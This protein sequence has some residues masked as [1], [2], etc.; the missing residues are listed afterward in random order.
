[1][2]NTNTHQYFCQTCRFDT[3]KKSKWERHLSTRKHKSNICMVIEPINEYSSPK[4]THD[5]AS[6]GEKTRTHTAFIC[7]CGKTY[8][9]KSNYSRHKKKC[10]ADGDTAPIIIDA[11][12]QDLKNDDDKID[13][14]LVMEIIKENKELRNI[15]KQQSEQISE[16]IPKIGNITN[17]NTTNKFNLNVFL[18]ERCK[19]ALNLED[20][21]RTI[22]LQ[23]TDLE[24][25][26]RLG[27]VNGMTNIIVRG[28]NDL[29]VTK[30]P[31]H[32]S[33]S[34]RDIL[35]VKDNNA[36]E[37]DNA[38][39][40]KMKRAI[41][42]ISRSN[43]KQIPNWVRENPECA[44]VRDPKNDVYMNMINETMDDNQEQQEKRNAKI[45]K[46]IAKTIMID[47]IDGTSS[48]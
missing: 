29:E 19:D 34:K 28:L 41:E 24:D 26:A 23:I 35:Y 3:P 9:Y 21:V 8:A 18:N 22:Q 31:I 38:G 30:R 20:F 40:D 37:R 14:D 1:M 39:N 12:K 4:E 27:Y 13:N 32:C 17:N 42:L 6:C 44:D 47:D 48:T 43:A 15:L 45:V 11:I 16:I 5:V 46:N 33:D 36:W 25:T 10:V 7:A 2:T